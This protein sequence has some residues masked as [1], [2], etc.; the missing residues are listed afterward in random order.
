MTEDTSLIPLNEAPFT[1][2]TLQRLFTTPT[3]PE[4]YQ[5][6]ETGV[7]DMLAAVLVGREIG[8]GPMEAI[9]SIYLVNGRTSMEAKLMSALIHRAGHKIKAKVAV[10]KTVIT[11]YRRDPYTHELDE[12]GTVEFG[13]ADAKRAKL[14]G[15]S[16]YEQY[17]QF[18]HTWRALGLAARLYYAD[19]LAGIG[20]IP[21]EVGAI[22]DIETSVPDD[23]ELEIETPTGEILEI[24]VDAEVVD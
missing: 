1:Y 20:H 3:V 14:D 7:D 4:R 11:C 24:P 2:K 8:I 19:C 16:T 9:N 5:L 10:T 23:L 21:E 12:V 18:M 17:P 22:D 6:S 15:K 13:A